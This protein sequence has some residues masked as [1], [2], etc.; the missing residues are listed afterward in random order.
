MKITIETETEKLVLETFRE[1]EQI[2]EQIKEQLPI[3]KEKAPIKKPK[4]I[5]YEKAKDTILSQ[6]GEFMF[7]D[8][9]KKIKDVP[10]GSIGNALRFLYKH[11]RV[12][13][14]DTIRGRTRWKV[15]SEP[16]VGDITREDRK[17]IIATIKS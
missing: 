6:S 10:K 14:V 16:K 3:F 13:K 17:N 7:E 11:E 1:K 12:K 2:K 15:V 4:Y 8:I 5:N 9:V